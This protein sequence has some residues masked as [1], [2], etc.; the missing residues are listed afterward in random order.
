MLRT[1][2]EGS[3]LDAL[4]LTG[5]VPDAPAHSSSLS[6]WPVLEVAPPAPAYTTGLRRPVASLLDQGVP[7]AAAELAAVAAAG[8]PR[9]RKAGPPLA[10]FFESS[11]ARPF[12]QLMAE[13]PATAAA[14]PR[15]RRRDWSSFQ[16]FPPHPPGQG[17]M[18]PPG[19]Q[20]QDHPGGPPMQPG[21]HPNQQ[22]GHPGQPGGGH[23]GGGNMAGGHGPPG[24]PGSPQDVNQFCTGKGYLKAADD[25]D[26]AEPPPTP[27]G[28]GKGAQKAAM[29]MGLLAPL[30][31][32]I[33]GGI[34]YNVFIKEP[35]PQLDLGGEE[36]SVIEDSDM[37]SSKSS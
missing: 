25:D 7:N 34:V 4:G 14:C 26:D 15:G 2:L 19:A 27:K 12:P 3:Q 21:P 8:G 11:V 16:A 1:A 9:R 13:P 17:P 18:P 37:V 31:M 23:M 35:P 32:I 24:M 22:M 28:G 33:T 36:L 10:S 29:L 30:G 6:S 20:F 5:Q